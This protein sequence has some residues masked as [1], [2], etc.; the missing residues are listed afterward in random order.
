MERKR[1]NDVL[2]QKRKK[3]LFLDKRSNKNYSVR[4]VRVHSPH[5]SKECLLSTLRLS[6]DEM[7]DIERKTINQMTIPLWSEECRKQLTALDFGVICKKLPH[8]N[9]KGRIKKKLYSHFQSLAMEY[10]ESHEGEALKSLED[11]GFEN[12]SSDFSYIQNCNI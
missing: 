7:K 3:N 8:M 10:G 12:S 11:S 6:N 1:E 4:S 2:K 9:C 5:P